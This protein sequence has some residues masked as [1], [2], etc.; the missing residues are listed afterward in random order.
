[1]EN[2]ILQTQNNSKTLLKQLEVQE[3]GFNLKPSLAIAMQRTEMELKNIEE[4][5]EDIATEFRHLTISEI[6]LALRNGSLAKYGR[7]YKLS[8][9]EVCF[10]IREYVKEKNNKSLKL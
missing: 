2:Q 10:W 1:M 6:K 8:T 5:I 9:Q 7:T 4:T 3:I